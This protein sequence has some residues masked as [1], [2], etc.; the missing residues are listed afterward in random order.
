VGAASSAIIDGKASTPDQDAVV[1]LVLRGG[2]SVRGACTGTLVAPNLVLTARHCVAET[3]EGALCTAAGSG[4]SGGTVHGDFAASDI[5]IYTGVDAALHAE[6][7]ARAAAHG[8][9]L[10]HEGSRTLCNAD[11]AFIV[12]DRNVPGRIAPLRLTGKA[13]EGEK[14]TAVGWGL[15]ETGSIPQKRMQRANVPVLAVGPMTLD[16]QNDIGLGAS[17]F[18]VGEAF[19]SGDSGGPSFSSK[20]A[21]VGVVSRGGGGGESASN[22]AANCVGNDVINFY[23]H[24]SNKGALVTKA[25]AAAG[26]EPRTEGDPPGAGAGE[27]CKADLD[28]SSDACVDGTCARRCD[29][30]TACETGETCTDRGEKKICVAAPAPEEPA[31]A[32]AAEA[33]AAAPSGTKTTITTTGCSSSPVRAPGPSAWTLVAVGAVALAAAKRRRRAR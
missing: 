20:G 23:T 7:P 33:P 3:D 21:V 11:I 15:T 24:L 2:G 31:D 32:P 13:R 27:A 6:N 8:Q 5:D 22:P 10:V 12:L 29:D 17:E 25:F 26:A 19:C 18:L 14:L 30:G 28:C 9:K 1:L 16:E 4:L